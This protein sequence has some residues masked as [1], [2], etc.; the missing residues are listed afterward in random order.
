MTLTENTKKKIDYWVLI[1]DGEVRN[2]F[3][4]RRLAV[5]YLKE[6][7][8]QALDDFKNQ[9]RTDEFDYSITI[10]KTEIKPINIRE[11]HLGL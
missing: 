8:K 9:D 1:R 11:A 7:L 10:P 4:S 3:V 6:I 2:V 5:K